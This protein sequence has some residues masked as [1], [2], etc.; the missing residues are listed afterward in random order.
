MGFH[1]GFLIKWCTRRERERETER[2]RGEVPNHLG[3]VE[4]ST[5]ATVYS[6][7]IRRRGGGGVSHRCSPVV[8]KTRAALCAGSP[9]FSASPDR[10]S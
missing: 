1:F 3:L 10:W 9:R 8:V 7:V 6:E 2:E 4:K 5:M